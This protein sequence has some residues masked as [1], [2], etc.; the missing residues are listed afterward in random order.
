M[1]QITI[2][3]IK[4]WQETYSFGF[5]D[6]ENNEISFYVSDAKQNF[7]ITCEVYELGCNNEA[8]MRIKCGMT[9]AMVVFFVNDSVFDYIEKL[10]YSDLLKNN[11]ELIDLLDKIL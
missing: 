5:L 9:D 6:Y 10:Y 7:Y 4:K 2:D 11:R 3:T 1:K 8:T